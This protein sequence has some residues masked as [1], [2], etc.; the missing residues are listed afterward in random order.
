MEEV[1]ARASGDAAV[2]AD[3]G[4]DGILVENYGDSPFFPDR[5]PPETV[6]ALAVA[7]REIVRCTSLPVG[8]NVLRNDAHAA[9]A[10]AAGAGARFVRVN[11][12]TGSMFTD[13]GLIQGQAHRTLRQRRSLGLSLPILADIMVK[14]ATP[15]PGLTLEAAARDSWFRGLGAG[16]ILTGTETGRPVELETIQQLREALP[17]EAKL[18]VGSGATPE[19]ASGLSRAAD[20]I[21]VGSSLQKGGLAGGG[22]DPSRVRTFMEALG[23]R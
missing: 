6:A 9:L 7:V 13:Q 17:T 10:V 21:I 23:R 16:L 22:I 20:G 18:W 11:V 5:V 15:P 12:H 8:V 14:H 19:T 2:L 3:G 1:L 4:L